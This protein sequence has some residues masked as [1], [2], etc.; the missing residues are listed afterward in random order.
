MSA[1]SLFTRV[2]PIPGWTTE[3]GFTNRRYETEAGMLRRRDSARWQGQEAFFTNGLTT[4]QSTATQT[5]DV[6]GSTASIDAGLATTTLRG[7]LGGYRFT[8]DTMR[9]T[10]SFKDGAGAALGTPVQIGPVTTA[11]RKNRT[12]LLRRE[13]TA[14]VPAGTRSITVTLIGTHGASTFLDVA[15]ADRIGLFLNTPEAPGTPPG[16]GSQ[17]TTPPETTIT[18][19]PKAKSAKAKAKYKFTSSEPNSSFDCAFD[20]KKF[21]PC[22]AGKAK[23]KRLDLGKHKFLVRAT[24]AAGNTDPS[25]DKDKFKRR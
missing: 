22:D 20:S 19:E 5:V 8:D 21:K 24:D 10:A 3:G 17:D 6:S 25:P 4:T 14:P 2:A 18:K 13:A 23:Y 7:Y 9:V 1:P 11:D 12:T 15:W 16:G